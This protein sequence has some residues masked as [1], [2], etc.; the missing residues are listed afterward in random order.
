MR[1]ASSYQ[2]ENELKWKKKV[3]SNTYNISSINV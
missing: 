2:G 3:N 1:N